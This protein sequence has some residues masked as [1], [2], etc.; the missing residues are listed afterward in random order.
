[1]SFKTR[2]GLPLAAAWMAFA[3]V[4]ATAAVPVAAPL[5][6]AARADDGVAGEAFGNDDVLLWLFGLIAL[7]GLT[8][9]AIGSG[10]SDDGAPTSP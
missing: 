4:A 8:F 2:I 5:T 1:M 3:P 6:T 7:F 10:S 9:A